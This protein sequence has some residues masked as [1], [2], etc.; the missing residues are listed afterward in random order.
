M[1]RYL[2]YS[3]WSEVAAATNASPA[4]REVF[5]DADGSRY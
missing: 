4:V 5:W 1:C 2:L 3:F